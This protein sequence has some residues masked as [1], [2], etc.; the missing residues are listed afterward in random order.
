MIELFVLGYG[1][2]DPFLDGEDVVLVAQVT[3]SL[4][5]NLDAP[6]C[7]QGRQVHSC[8]GLNTC[9]HFKDRVAANTC[10]AD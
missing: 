10:M 2:I 4:P 7:R 3:R 6:W 5:R 8:S 1:V 9:M